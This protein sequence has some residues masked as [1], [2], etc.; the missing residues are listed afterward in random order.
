[1]ANIELDARVSSISWFLRQ[2]INN[3]AENNQRNIVS[4]QWSPQ[5]AKLSSGNYQEK[6]HMEKTNL[7]LYVLQIQD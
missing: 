6:G 3:Q 4:N 5:Q 2:I 1:M 7:C